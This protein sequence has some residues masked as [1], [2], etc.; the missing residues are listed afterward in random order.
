MKM[1]R[2]VLAAAMAIAV[3]CCA[4]RPAAAEEAPWCAVT[5]LGWGGVIEDCSYWSFKA[6]VPFVIAGNR[7]FCNRNPRYEGPMPKPRRI[8]RH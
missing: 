8:R 7:G 5:P 4:T 1:N 2:S 6:C 3:I